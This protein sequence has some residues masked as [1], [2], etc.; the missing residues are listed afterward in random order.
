MLSLA[1]DLGERWVD[2]DETDINMVLHIRK[3]EGE[4]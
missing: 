3:A 4:R 2:A 1:P